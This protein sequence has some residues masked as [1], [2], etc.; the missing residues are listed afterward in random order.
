MAKK[1]N[2]LTTTSVK[3]PS[4]KVRQP[5]TR[6]YD[7]TIWV[8]AE[9][10]EKKQP[11][12]RV[13][14]N[15]SFNKFMSAIVLALTV[16]AVVVIILWVW[17]FVF[18]TRPTTNFT[19]Q[20]ST[21]GS[22]DKEYFMEFNL[23]KNTNGNAER[24]TEL[25]LNYYTSES[26]QTKFSTGIQTIGKV[27]TYAEKVSQNGWSIF[28][29]DWV[30]KYHF[31]TEHYYYNVDANGHSYSA[32]EQIS[33]KDYYII[34]I[35]NKIYQLAFEN[36]T[37]QSEYVLWINNRVV[38][39]PT[40]LFTAMGSAT[41]SLSSGDYVI[42]FPVGQFFS[43]WELN[44][45]GKFIK[46]NVETKNKIYV[47]TK[48]HIEDEGVVNHVQSIFNNVK[49][50]PNY[51][52]DGI[53]EKNYWK[54]ETSLILTNRHFEN[55]NGYLSL[56]KNLIA[57]LNYYSNLYVAVNLNL[58]EF[59]DVK[60]FDYYAFYGV[61]LQEIKL[62]SNELRDFEVRNLALKNTGVE[63]EE[64]LTTNVNLVEV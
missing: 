4:T 10:V 45:D 48:V 19:A 34:E 52:V 27:T 46:L 17:F 20:I 47:E 62:T 26:L 29:N 50:N 21:I 51:N 40:S 49:G 56:N 58:N 64:I 30:Y 12:A 32:I 13:K 24:L 36:N 33:E 60:G 7:D 14:E 6:K 9:V 53:E 55:N 5:S 63:L 23:L 38:S 2:E 44:E 39:D 41:Q 35:D 28:S 57:Y 61:D 54:A 18:N 16:L 3:V 59:E 22:E 31:T 1:K 8:D 42:N 15:N 11:K 43:M 25:K 37:I